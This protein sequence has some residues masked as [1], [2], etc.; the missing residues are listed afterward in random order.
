MLIFKLILYSLP[1]SNWRIPPSSKHRIFGNTNLYKFAGQRF[2]PCRERNDRF[3]LFVS[4]SNY[5]H[6]KLTWTSMA[7]SKSV[8]ILSPS[9]G[10]GRSFPAPWH[11]TG[12]F[13][14]VAIL[15]SRC[16]RLDVSELGRL[17]QQPWRYSLCERRFPFLALMANPIC[18]LTDA[19]SWKTLRIS[20]SDFLPHEIRWLYGVDNWAS[21]LE[22][23]RTEFLKWPL[24]GSG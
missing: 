16:L 9:G 2:C 19:G 1:S 17:A 4:F 14:I 12:A 6:L 11:S 15:L 23:F 10:R 7:G 8:E 5:L 18:Q 20:G 22:H 13:E 3:N 24:D 21:R